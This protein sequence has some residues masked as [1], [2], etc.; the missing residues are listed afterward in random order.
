MKVPDLFVGKRFFVGLGNPLA[1]GLGPTEIRGSAFVEGPM[2]VGDPITYPSVE[3]NLMVSRCTNTD[4]TSVPPSIFKVSS[5][6]F[7]PT[8]LDV[9]LGD[10]SGKVG[11]SVN[12]IVVNIINDTFINIRTESLTGNGRYTW[13]GDKVLSGVVAENGAESR[14]GR[15]SVSGETVDNGPKTINSNLTVAGFINCAWLNNELSIAKASPPKGFDMHHP[16][17]PGWRLTHIC[18]EG[19]E[20]AVYH[21]GVLKNSNVIELPDYWKGLVDVETITVHLT[22]I[23][24]YQELSYEII[25]WGTKIKVINNAGS[26]VNC[27]YIVYGERKDVDKIVVEYEGKIEDYPGR[28]QRSIVGYHYDYR[29]GLNS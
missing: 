1:L 3:A 29:P 18:L 13:N 23:Q 4:L 7:A 11:I 10:A 25:D 6:A 20:A 17:K 5:K 16:T 26:A 15:E 2:I 21:R 9:V 27:S 28:D 12:S 8:Q 24:T 14:N 22:S 19:P